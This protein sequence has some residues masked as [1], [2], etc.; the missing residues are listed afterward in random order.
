MSLDLNDEAISDLSVEVVSK[1]IAYYRNRSRRKYSD[2]SIEELNLLW[3]QM[4]TVIEVARTVPP[5]HWLYSFRG[6]RS[7]TRLFY[8]PEGYELH[9]FAAWYICELYNIEL[10]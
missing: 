4:K 2:L 7:S 1:V 6:E 10:L 3:A 5:D 8:I 9:Y